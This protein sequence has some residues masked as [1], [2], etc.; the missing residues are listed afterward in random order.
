MEVE[1]QRVPYFGVWID[2]GMVNDRNI[3]ALEPSIGYYD[4]LDRAMANGTAAVVPPGGSNE[5]SLSLR[6]GTGGAAAGFP[7]RGGTAEQE[8]RIRSQ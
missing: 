6:L 5:W 4:A 7:E 8:I 3:I 1:S 2:E